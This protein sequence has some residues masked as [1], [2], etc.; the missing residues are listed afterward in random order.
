MRSSDELAVLVVDDNPGVLR[1]LRAWVREF[2]YEALATSNPLD[3]RSLAAS[4]GARLAIVDVNM[5]EM[6]GFELL[7]ELLRADSEM[8]VIMVTGDRSAETLCQAV[9]AGAWDLLWKPID[10]RQLGES[11]NSARERLMERVPAAS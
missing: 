6:G 11:L 7:R 8:R 1:L 4:H 10:G 3:A 9:Q 2:G 5:P